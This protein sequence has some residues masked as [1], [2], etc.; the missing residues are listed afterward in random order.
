MR[1]NEKSLFKFVSSGVFVDKEGHL[2]KK[3][4]FNKGYQKRYFVLKGNLF[5]YYEKRYDKE[6]VGVIVLEGC[7]IE[8]FENIDGFVF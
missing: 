2:L 3:G 7:I 4:E 1:I 5:F 6:F 8:F